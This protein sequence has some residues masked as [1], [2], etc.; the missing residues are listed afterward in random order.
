M[1]GRRYRAEPGGPRSLVELVS[2]CV[3]LTSASVVCQAFSRRKGELENAMPP[4]VGVVV[5]SD[6][7]DAAESIPERCTV[8]GLL[9]ISHDIPVS[10]MKCNRGTSCHRAHD[11][12]T[13][14]S[15]RAATCRLG[16]CKESCKGR[17]RD[18]E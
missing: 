12:D 17:A 5:A 3:I 14:G 1:C 6:E 15:G 2:L 9:V 7:A 4:E 10:C 18:A 11:K 16:R 8:C 13:G